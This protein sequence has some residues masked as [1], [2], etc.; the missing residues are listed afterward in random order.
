MV[1]L[2]LGGGL[3]NQMFQYAF[4]RKVQQLTQDDVLKFTGYHLKG[5][6]NSEKMLF[7]LNI[8]PGITF[9]DEKE[10]QEVERVQERALKKCIITRFYRAIL[11]GR[12]HGEF[13]CCLKRG[14]IQPILCIMNKNMKCRIAG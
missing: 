12:L 5:T 11:R 1:V 7:N 8:V 10:Q 3:G 14:F 6:G 4:A 2:T 13:A 9:C